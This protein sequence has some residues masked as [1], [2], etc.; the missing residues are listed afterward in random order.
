M[1]F[2]RFFELA[3]AK[4]IN[5]CDL[6][7]VESSSFSF[8]LF[9]GEIDNYETSKDLS[10]TVRGIVDGKFGSVS[11]SNYDPKKLPE[12]IDEIISNA[13]TIEKIEPNFIFKGSPKYKKIKAF[14]KDL[15]TIEVNKKIALLH[16]LE[17]KLKAYDPRISEVAEVYYS[18]NENVFR[19]SNSYGLNL[20]S[21]SNYFA[22]GGEVIAKDGEQTK[23]GY[24]SYIGNDLNKLNI[25]ELVKKIADQ[26]LGQLNGE[27][28]NTGKYK[29]ILS[30]DVL[31]AF[32]KTFVGYASSESVQK[33]SSLFEGKLNTKVASSKV[34]IIDKPITKS[35]FT[36]GFDDE[37]V[38]TYNKP[39]V[40]NGVL[41]T[42]LYNLR[43]AAKDGV[44]STG[45]AAGVGS[46]V[47]VGYGY[48]YFKP[49]KKSLEEMM[50][51]VN[52]GLYITSV[53]GLNAGLNHQSG[54][55]SLK[56]E[57][58]MI[59]NG[60][61]THALDIITISGNIIKLFKDIEEVGSHAEEYSSCAYI[62]N[63]IVKS[64]NVSGK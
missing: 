64:L 23:S 38:A 24:D 29:V 9:H 10:L 22:I 51:K 42:Y 1:N 4:N 15:P 37:G 45:N 43:T 28:C 32:T 48:I 16:E 46:K 40:K 25:D 53:T 49:G 6:S 59:E 50:A 47:G 55:F 63:A 41:Q 14:N 31:C 56:A 33:H 21:K 7:L 58:F 5:E 27:Q 39:I 3:D 34:T 52:N 62:P 18:E 44:T 11:S 30:N 26:A 20:S 13:K 2:K 36:R 35:I 19:L 17:D 61:K 54:D 8:S 57:G 60:K 12:M